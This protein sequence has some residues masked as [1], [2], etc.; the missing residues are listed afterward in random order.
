MSRLSFVERSLAFAQLHGKHQLIAHARRSSC[1]GRATSRTT[2]RDELDSRDLIY[3]IDAHERHAL[4]TRTSPAPASTSGRSSTILS[5][6][7]GADLRIRLGQRAAARAARVAQLSQRAL[8]G[9]RFRYSYVGNDPTV[10]A[11][12]AEEMFDAEHIGTDFSS[13][14]ARSTRTPT[15]RRSTS[16]ARLRDGRGRSSTTSCA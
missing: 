12:A 9:R 5:G 1:A 4:R 15:R 10:R 13:R 2:T 8:G 3:T 7:G 16:Y 11:L 14:R 6:G